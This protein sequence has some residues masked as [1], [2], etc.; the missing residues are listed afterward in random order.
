MTGIMPVS[1]GAK[2]KGPFSANKNRIAG[3]NCSNCS[4]LRSILV[5]AILHSHCC[6]KCYILTQAL[7]QERGQTPQRPAGSDSDKTT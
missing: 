6:V 4:A 2:T 7:S 1:V 3:D 5:A